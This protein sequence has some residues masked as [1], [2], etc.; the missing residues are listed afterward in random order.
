MYKEITR[1]A[2]K[3]L[4]KDIPN[5]NQHPLSLVRNGRKKYHIVDCPANNEEAEK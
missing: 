5:W 2:T 3:P 1:D 4:R